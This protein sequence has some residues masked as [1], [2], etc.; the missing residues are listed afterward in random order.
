MVEKINRKQPGEISSFE[1][2][3]KTFETSNDL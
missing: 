3:I 1:T 2:S